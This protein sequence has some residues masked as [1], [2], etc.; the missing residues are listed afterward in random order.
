MPAKPAVP[1]KFSSWVHFF[2]QGGYEDNKNS[3]A[4]ALIANTLYH[5][6][7]TGFPALPRA[8]INAI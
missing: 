5:Y 4:N 3:S 8:I 2:N 1:V 6:Q 7:H